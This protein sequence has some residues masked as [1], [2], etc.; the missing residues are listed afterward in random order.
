MLRHK[1]NS[2][3]A[4]QK[5]HS[6]HVKLAGKPDALHPQLYRNTPVQRLQFNQHLNQ[7]VTFCLELYH[8][9]IIKKLSEL[10]KINVYKLTKNVCQT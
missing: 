7:R 9:N 6:E 10:R 1:R 5:T 3:N 4:Q 2:S 8:K